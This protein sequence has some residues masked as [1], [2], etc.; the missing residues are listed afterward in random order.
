MIINEE[1]KMKKFIEFVLTLLLNKNQYSELYRKIKFGFGW[2]KKKIKGKEDEIDLF[3]YQKTIIQCQENYTLYCDENRLY[4]LESVLERYANFKERICMASEHGFFIEKV[5][6][7]GIYEGLPSIITFGNY[8]KKILENKTDCMVLKIGP[9]IHYAQ[10]IWDDI[11]IEKIKKHNGKTLLVFPAHTI[12]STRY[13]K[14]GYD[15]VEIIK[16]YKEKYAYTTV[17][18]S[19]YFID[20]LKQE[21]KQ[22]EKEGFLIFSAGHRNNIDFLDRLKTVFRLADHVLSE[23]VGT[24]IGYS[25]CMNKPVTICK[26][27]YQLIDTERDYFNRNNRD[28]SDLDKIISVFLQHNDYITKEQLEICNYYFGNSEIKSP[29]ELYECFCF[30]RR[31]YNRSLFNGESYYHNIKKELNSFKYSQ[32]ILDMAKTNRYYKKCSKETS[33]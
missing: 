15:F 19:L 4:G 32:M 5:P 13:E 16:Y 29:E 9:Y 26:V 25:I 17:I 23:G 1:S 6:Y 14:D 24:H 18:I 33:V 8:R 2:K 20:I 3:D 27:H 10:E 7:L 12:E 31:V 21:Y 22:Y 30:A 11:K 28:K